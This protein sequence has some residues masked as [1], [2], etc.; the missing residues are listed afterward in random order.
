[1]AVMK[2]IQTKIDPLHKATPKTSETLTKINDR[3]QAM[4]ADTTK[5]HPDIIQKLD[6]IDQHFKN[7]QNSFVE[8]M[9]QILNEKLNPFLEQQKKD[10]EEKF[11]KISYNFTYFFTHI[12]QALQIEII[13]LIVQIVFLYV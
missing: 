9:K 4:H 2:D 13:I 8:P 1:M 11:G 12:S 10:G 7:Q 5:P 3:V 6:N